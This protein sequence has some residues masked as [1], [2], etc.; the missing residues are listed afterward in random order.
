[1]AKRSELVQKQVDRANRM[2]SIETISQKEKEV[3]CCMIEQL[4]MDAKCYQGFNYTYW[5]EKGFTEWMEAGKPVNHIPFLGN[6]Y[7]RHYY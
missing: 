3:V 7:D 2:L 5:M 6:E 1:M 4:L